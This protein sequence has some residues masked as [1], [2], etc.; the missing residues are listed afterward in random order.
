D[1][2]ALP[3]LVDEVD[4]PRDRVRLEDGARRF[5]HPC[6]VF[7]RGAAELDPLARFHGD[8]GTLRRAHGRWVWARSLGGEGGGQE[9][10]VRIG[11]AVLGIDGNGQL[12]SARKEPVERDS[13]EAPWAGGG[14]SL[15]DVQRENEIGWVNR[16][17]VVPEDPLPAVLSSWPCFPGVR[18]LNPESDLFSQVEDLCHVNSQERCRVGLCRGVGQG[19][20][21]RARETRRQPREKIEKLRVEPGRPE[22]SPSE[23]RLEVLPGALP[24]VR[25]GLIPEVAGVKA[26]LFLKVLRSPIAKGSQGLRFLEPLAGKRE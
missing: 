6:D 17:A 10:P 7:T 23:E 12:G 22:L 4:A 2:G 1:Q 25:A 16:V 21:E 24:E 15:G 9:R 18:E 26:V 5:G 3:A 13:R 8:A 19:H 14:R 20:H 11:N